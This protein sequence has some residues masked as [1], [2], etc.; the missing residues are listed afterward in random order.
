MVEAVLKEDLPA[1]ETTQD[2]QGGA[3]IWR[4]TLEEHE[5]PVLD[6]AHTVQEIP[7]EKAKKDENDDPD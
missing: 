4:E 7:K 6:Y 1:D 5:L 3:F 2:P